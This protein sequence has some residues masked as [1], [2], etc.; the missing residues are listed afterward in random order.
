MA[1]A[2]LWQ[3]LRTVANHLP[4]GTPMPVSND[5]VLSLLDAAERDLAAVPSEPSDRLL[6][7]E[8]VATRLSISRQQVYRDARRWPFTRKLSPKVLRFSEAGLNRWLDR[9]GR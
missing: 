6:T 1:T 2:E 3:A 4:A 7:A 9:R 5:T 8:E